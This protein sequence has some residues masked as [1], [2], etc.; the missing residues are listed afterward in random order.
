M[1]KFF[2]FVLMSLATLSIAQN[3]SGLNVDSTTY[4]KKLDYKFDSS[5]LKGKK[6]AKIYYKRYSDAATITLTAACG[7]MLV[8]PVSGLA[9]AIA[10]SSTPPKIKN[11][12]IPDSN[13]LQNGNYMLGY[14]HQAKKMKQRKVW[15][16]WAIGFGIN[17]FVVGGLLL[18]PAKL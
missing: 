2:F 13:Y 14:R 12:N 6:D 5:F 10:C 3:K 11:L 15:Q 1:F 4:L 17:I 18:I 7:L 9:T 16:N 8:S